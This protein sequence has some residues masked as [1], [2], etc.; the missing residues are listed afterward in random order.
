MSLICHNSKLSATTWS[1]CLIKLDQDMMNM[2]DKHDKYI[3]IS[4]PFPLNEIKQSIQQFI[5]NTF[6]NGSLLFCCDL[7]L[8]FMTWDKKDLIKHLK[9]HYP[10]YYTKWDNTTYDQLTSTQS[11]IILNVQNCQYL[12]IPRNISSEILSKPI[13]FYFDPDN[14]EYSELCESVANNIANKYLPENFNVSNDW[15]ER[16]EFKESTLIGYLCDDGEIIRGDLL[17]QSRN[18][19][20]VHFDGD[21][22]RYG[23]KCDWINVPNQR[24]CPPPKERPKKK[25][26]FQTYYPTTTNN[27]YGGNGVQGYRNWNDYNYYDYSTEDNDLQRAIAA[28]LQ[29]M[30]NNSNNNAQSQDTIL[31]SSID[32]GSSND[33]R[34]DIDP[35]DDGDQ[36]EEEEEDGDFFEQAVNA[37][38]LF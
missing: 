23:K 16:K 4:L 24:I 25:N 36:D 18:K 27:N 35:R 6:S 3:I 2:Y 33:N 28:S 5:S 38:L 13:Y 7:I 9:L 30:N 10:Y 20:F 19:I 32:I 21:S 11:L 29:D 26:N 37:S 22:D 8:Q 31:G 34:G 1:D 14:K 12:T 17:R 15:S